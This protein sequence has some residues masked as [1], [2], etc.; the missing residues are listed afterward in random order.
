M[1]ACYGH[2][3]QCSTFSKNFTI[4]LLVSFVDKSKGTQGE[5]RHSPHQK[6]PRSSR[7]FCKSRLPFTSFALLNSSFLH[8]LSST[9]CTWESHCQ[10]FAHSFHFSSHLLMGLASCSNSST[11]APPLHAAAVVSLCKIIQVTN[12]WCSSSLF[13]SS[14]LFFSCS[15]LC[16]RCSVSF[17]SR[18]SHVFTISSKKNH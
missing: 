12:F 1:Y 5:T 15:S 10:C 16:H 11:C 17:Y 13:F 2:L 9:P 7:S 6:Y 3:P 4:Y 18:W 14:F 8:S